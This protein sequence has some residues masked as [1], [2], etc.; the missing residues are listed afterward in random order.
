MQIKFEYANNTYYM[1]VEFLIRPQI[2][3]T[4]NFTYIFLRSTHFLLVLLTVR[5]GPKKIRTGP[6]VKDRK[7][8]KKTEKI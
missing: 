6:N 5:S 2:S 4:S 8:R 1:Y 7:D 3:L